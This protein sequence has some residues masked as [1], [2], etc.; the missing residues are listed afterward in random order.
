M[1]STTPRVRADGRL[2]HVAFP[3]PACGARDSRVDRRY[4]Y[5]ASD[6]AGL[7]AFQR[8]R[9]RVLFEHWFPGALE[10]ERRARR[11]RP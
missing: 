10:V 8:L 6:Y 4:A 9:R 5:R 2:V 11:R 3:C 1:A 7:T